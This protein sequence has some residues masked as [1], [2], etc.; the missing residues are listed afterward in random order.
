MANSQSRSVQ[1]DFKSRRHA[2]E[3]LAVDAENFRGSLSIAAG[4]VEHVE[5][6]APLQFVQA[7]QSRKESARSS[8]ESGWGELPECSRKSSVAD[9]LR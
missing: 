8:A 2:V 4:R 9:H 5:N 7:R 6:V 1:I 3:G